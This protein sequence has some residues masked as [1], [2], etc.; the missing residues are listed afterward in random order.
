MNSFH[1]LEI[2]MK[3][4]TPESLLQQRTCKFEI[5]T[6]QFIDCA[7]YIFHAAVVNANC[8]KK[9]IKSSVIYIRTHYISFKLKF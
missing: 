8:K 3:Y 6:C 1:V 9:I 7:L 5:N 4:R 2:K